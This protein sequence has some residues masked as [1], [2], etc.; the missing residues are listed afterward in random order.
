M[1]MDYV[2]FGI[3]YTFRNKGNVERD[4]SIK[5]KTLQLTGLFHSQPQILTESVA[6]L[7]LKC[8]F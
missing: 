8:T 3:Q 5:V 7:S 6:M 4:T 1:I 2:P